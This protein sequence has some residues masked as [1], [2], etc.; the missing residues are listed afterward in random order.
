M[1]AS[2]ESGERP[3][4]WIFCCALGWIFFFQSLSGLAPRFWFIAERNFIGG[5]SIH[6]HQHGRA[7]RNTRAVH[8]F[9]HSIRTLCFEVV[10][11]FFDFRAWVLH[12]RKSARKSLIFSFVHHS[13][14]DAVLVDQ[15]SGFRHA[16]FSAQ[17][18]N[19][20]SNVSRAGLRQNL[21][22]L[23]SKPTPAVHNSQVSTKSCD[24]RRDVVRGFFFV[25]CQ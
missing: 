8:S 24:V 22:M 2:P 5:D 14:P 12:C 10:V 20:R 21:D 18:L 7:H 1:N 9:R 13:T 17:S 11:V 3:F 6:S 25:Q 15:Y 19:S 4:S 16:V 23:D